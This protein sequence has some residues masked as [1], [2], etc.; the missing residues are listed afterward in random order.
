VFAKA[1]RIRPKYYWR[2]GW[3]HGVKRFGMDFQRYFNERI[4]RLTK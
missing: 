3:Q 4:R 2:D 1:V